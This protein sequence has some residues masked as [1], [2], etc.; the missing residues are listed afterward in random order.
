MLTQE[1]FAAFVG[2]TYARINRWENGRA[3]PSTEEPN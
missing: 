2:V 1:K 3:K